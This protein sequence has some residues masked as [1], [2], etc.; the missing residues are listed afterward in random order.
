M[1]MNC[2]ELKS[3]IQEY[4]TRELSPDDRHRVDAHVME[5][6]DCRRELALMSAVVSGLDSQPVSEPPVGFAARVME[7]LPRQ[8]ELAPSPWWSLAA[9]PILG[10]LAYLFRVPLLE[11]VFRLAGRAG[12]GQV[13]VAEFGIAQ[14]AAVTAAAVFL[15]LG[16]T[17]GAATYCWRSC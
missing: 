3:L 1:D 2:K 15:A 14:I 13:P 17:A 5:C 16:V 11:L 8:R 12:I 10:V 4:A 7:R 6:D 9:A